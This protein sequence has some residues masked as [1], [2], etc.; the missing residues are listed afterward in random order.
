ML[1]ALNST[2]SVE[3]EGGARWFE[4][5]PLDPERVVPLL[6]KGFEYPGTRS[7]CACALRAYGPWA[8]FA[9][10]R[11]VTLTRSKY[12]AVSLEATWVLAGIDPEAAQKAR[13]PSP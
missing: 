6:L 11:L 2:D 13:V 8:R 7:D 9:V 12:P 10:E 1:R 3:V 4:R 5:H